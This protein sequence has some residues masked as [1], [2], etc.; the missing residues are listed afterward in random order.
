MATVA[1]DA[2]AQVRSLAKELRRELSLPEVLLWRQLRGRRLEGLRFRRQH[3]I[4]P[5]ILDFYCAEA[6]LAVEVDGASHYVG[7]R[8]ERDAYRDRWLAESGIRTLRLPARYVLTD[9]NSA[10]HTIL[11]EI[12]GRRPG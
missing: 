5:F 11:H 7:D 9:L 10:L 6:K 2:P 3:P 8:Q 4:G 12:G 1:M